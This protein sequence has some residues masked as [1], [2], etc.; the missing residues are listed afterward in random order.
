MLQFQQERLRSESVVCRKMDGILAARQAAD[1]KYEKERKQVEALR[2]QFVGANKT[3][4]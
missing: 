4:A 1:L 3:A 2:G